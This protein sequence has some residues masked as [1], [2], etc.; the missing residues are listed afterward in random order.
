MLS[1]YNLYT[2][3]S[4]PDLYKVLYYVSIQFQIYYKHGKICRAKCS[5]IPHNEWETVVVGYV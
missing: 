3:D 1:K 2:F 4:S 5:Q